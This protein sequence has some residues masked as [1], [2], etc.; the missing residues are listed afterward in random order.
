MKRLSTL[1]A[2]LLLVCAVASF[3]AEP[4]FTQPILLTSCGQSADVL[5]LKT[6][7]SKDSLTFSYLP[8][9]AATDLAGKGSLILVIGGSSK[10]LGAAKISS[11][12]E[13]AR[14]AALLDAARAGGLSVIAVHMGGM[15]RRGALSDPFNQLGAEKADKIFVVK[16]GNDDGYFTKIAD[17]KKIPMETMNTA[18]EV[19][20]AIKAIYHPA[21]EAK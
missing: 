12:Q 11:E 16:G 1:A 17:E 2:A 6:L 15:N 19:G 21:V 13:L 18:L 9:A 5:M 4:S 20:P 3:A 14:V 10:G 8:N 7:M